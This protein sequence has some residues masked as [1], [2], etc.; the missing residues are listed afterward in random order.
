MEGVPRRREIEPVW[1]DG[2]AARVRELAVELIDR[3]DVLDDG[4]RLTMLR[5]IERGTATLQVIC[6][7]PADVGSVLA[8]V[9]DL[10]ARELEVLRALAEGGTTA[11]V[12]EELS[13][14]VATVRS[15]VKNILVKLGMHSRTEAVAWALQRHLISVL[16]F[17]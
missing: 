10:S 11:S 16:K 3:W 17:R 6:D 1:A 5:A 13:I 12:A 15:H 2:L 8:T 4:S 14:S 9:P 7:D